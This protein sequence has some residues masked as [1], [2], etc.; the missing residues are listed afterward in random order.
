M[1]M[2]MM[3]MMM[4][5]LHGWEENCYLFGSLLLVAERL[6]RF[7]KMRMFFSFLADMY[8]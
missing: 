1:M 7:L 5:L 4:R 3:M 6:L 8:D 2:T